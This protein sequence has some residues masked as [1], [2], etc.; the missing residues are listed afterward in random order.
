MFAKKLLPFLLVALGAIAYVA[1]RTRPVHTPHR[2]W[3]RF[4]EGEPLD[5]KSCH[6]IQGI[7]T[8]EEAHDFFGENAVM[9]WTYTVEEKQTLYHLSIFFEKDGLYAVCEGSR[10]GNQILLF[11]HWR[12]AAAN[13]TGTVELI[14]DTSR[15]K[16]T[17]KGRYGFDDDV[18]QHPFTLLQQEPLPHKPPFEIIAHR[19]GARNVD[20]LPVSENTTDMLKMA[21]RLG[22]TGVEIDVRLTKDGVPVIFHDSFLSIHTVQKKIYGG[23]L[24]NYNYEELRE[25]E[26]RKGGQIPTLEECLHTILYCTPLQ[27]VWLDIKKECDL[28]SI[29]QLQ[30][31]YMMAAASIG[32]TLNIYI[33]IPDKMIFGCFQSLPDHQE[34]LSIVELEPEYVHQVNADV[35]APQYTEGTEEETVASLHAAGKKVFVWSLD[36]RLLIDHYVTNGGFDGLITNASPVAAHWYY[37]QPEEKLHKTKDGKETVAAQADS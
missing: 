7:Y 10:Q 16:R 18:P 26:L 13:G 22:A 27:T 20:F 30:R 4:D 9:K 2:R 28:A 21:A 32:R 17:I 15:A 34:A 37:T 3:R 1:Y 25:I 23:M 12:K 6:A 19:G 8:I 35:W 29:R 36:H 31:Q 11:G 14:I 24:H 5:A 33:G